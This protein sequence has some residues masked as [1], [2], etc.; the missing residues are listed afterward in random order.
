MRKYTIRPLTSEDQD[1]LW[2]IV[3]HAIHVP[4]GAE[5]PPRSILSE[6]GV[7]KYVCEWGRPGD[8]GLLAED[9]ESLEIMGAAWL[10]LF[11][12]QDPGYGFLDENIP[13]LSV[14]LFPGFRGKGVGTALMT[15]IFDH[16]KTLYPAVSLSVVATNPALRLYERLGFQ[17]V[18]VTGNSITAQLRFT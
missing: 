3:Y 18:S 5:P 8:Y 17:R 6:P 13:E 1:F 4:P 12:R 11:T 9:S 10:R 14:A 15:R 7:S 2:E 16:A